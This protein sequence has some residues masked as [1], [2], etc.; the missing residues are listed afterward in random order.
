MTRLLSP[1]YT[2]YRLFNTLNK[3][4]GRHTVLVE[5]YRKM[6]VKCLL[7][8][9]NKMIHSLMDFVVARLLKFAGCHS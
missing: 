4:S 2:V 8:L 6:Y 7:I 1:D 3:S 5:Q 9:S